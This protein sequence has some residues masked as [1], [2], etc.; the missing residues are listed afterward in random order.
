MTDYIVYHCVK[1]GVSCPD[2]IAAAWV[3]LKKFPA[4]TLLGCCYQDEE[5]PEFVKG[6]RV[7][8][9]DFSFPAAV[10]QWWADNDVQLIVIDHHQTAINNLMGLSGISAHFDLQECGATLAW[11][12]LFPF[13][14]MP[15][16]LEYVRDRDL[17]NFRL[18]YSQE[19]HEAVSHLK[20]E[21]KKLDLSVFE[22]FE[23]LAKLNQTELIAFLR[24]IGDALL[25][26]KRE[27]IDA[28]ARRMK[29][30]PLETPLVTYTVPVVELAKDGSEDRLTSDICMKLY[31]DMPGVLFVACITSD[32]S[33]SLRSDKDGSN[34]NVR[35]VAELMG[36]GGHHNAAGFKRAEG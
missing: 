29:L 12:V 1:P 22:L 7:I 32:G 16:F 36:G 8:I 2:G 3:A 35:E 17:W 30:M 6:D 18:F 4:A 24:P 28:A 27:K 20:Y 25:A 26:P 23:G 11:K 19:I 15:M 31:R 5:Y 10:M 13:E 34:F 14:P 33:W 9:V 21:L